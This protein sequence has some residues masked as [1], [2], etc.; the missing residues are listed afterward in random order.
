MPAVDRCL[1]IEPLAVV[2]DVDDE[3]PVDDIQRHPLVAC[4]AMAKPVGERLLQQPEQRDPHR[5]RRLVRDIADGTAAPPRPSCARGRRTARRTVSATES[6]S[7]SGSCRPRR[8]ARMSVSADCSATWMVWKSSAIAAAVAACMR[9]GAADFGQRFDA[10]RR[11]R[12]ALPRSVVQIGGDVAQEPFVQRRRAGAG[13]ADPVVQLLVLS[14]QC[15]ELVH[16]FAELALLRRDR[17]GRP[18]HQCREQRQHGQCHCAV[19]PPA[20]QLRRAHRLLH[21][22]RRLVEVRH[23]DDRPVPIGANGRVGLDQAGPLPL[24]E[25]ALQLARVDDARAH[26]AGKSA[27]RWPLGR[28]RT[29]RQRRVCTVEDDPAVQAPDLQHDDVLAQ[30]RA[31]QLS[32]KCD[33]VG[34]FERPAVRQ[35]LQV[36]RDGPIQVQVGH[37]AHAVH[38]AGLDLGAHPGADEH[39]RRDQHTEP[40]QQE[41]VHQTQTGYRFHGEH[42]KF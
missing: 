26:L 24:L 38:D 8:M 4:A 3:L 25:Y 31:R 1:G 33:S 16:L 23:R 41:P 12:Q 11:Q 13:A 2:A 39:H 22:V 40:D 21:A 7:I 14:Q 29:D 30:V 20:A 27:C 34:G 32:V 17:I 5:Q 10:H 42:R 37:D 35:R 18:S 9:A 28:A 19:H 15:R 6:C 36:R